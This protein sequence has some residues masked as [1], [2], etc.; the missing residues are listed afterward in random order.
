MNKN[1]KISGWIKWVQD[2]VKGFPKRF[3]KWRR[4]GAGVVCQVVVA[5]AVCWWLDLWAWMGNGSDEKV[6]NSETLRNLAL[7]GGLLIGIP[8]ALRRNVVATRQVETSE[9]NLRNERYQ[10]GANMLGSDT[11]ATRLG[12]IYALEHL[13]KDHPDEYHIQIM[14]LLCVFVR[15]PRTDKSFDVEAPI[16]PDVEA[17]VQAIGTRGE[18]GKKLESDE[19]WHLDLHG[20]NLKGAYLIDTDLTGAKLEYANLTD[21]ELEDANLTGADMHHANLTDARMYRAN[22]T[23]A[24]M[25]RANLTDANMSHANLTS[26]RISR[27]NLTDADISHAN[28][29]GARMFGANLTDADISHANLTGARI[30]RANLTDADMSNVNISDARLNQVKGLTQESLNMARALK[31]SP[32]NI[33]ESTCAETDEPLTWTGGAGKPLT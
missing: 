4:S 24:R 21:A 6:S 7:I 19:K 18:D 25:Y 26:A 2:H 9:R 31:D 14:K 29:T 28:L 3:R 12:G 8:L 1:S 32:P 11:L 30:S 5:A 13:A 23:G 33:S 22:L 10:T 16:R 20:A 17:A 27:A 15:H